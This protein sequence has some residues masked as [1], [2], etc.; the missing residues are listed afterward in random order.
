[1]K[2]IRPMAEER[3]RL[4]REDQASKGSAYIDHASDTFVSE[5]AHAKEA[6]RSDINTYGT[7]VWTNHHQKYANYCCFGVGRKCL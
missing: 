1:M 6:K 3:A 2:D 7:Y 4:K 5:R